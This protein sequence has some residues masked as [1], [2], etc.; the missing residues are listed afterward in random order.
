LKEVW[1]ISFPRPL[2]VLVGR[3]PSELVDSFKASFLKHS[4]SQQEANPPAKLV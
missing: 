1:L 2:A 4:L 3:H